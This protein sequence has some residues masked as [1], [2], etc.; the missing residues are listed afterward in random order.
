MLKV[1]NISKSYNGKD[2]LNDINFSLDEG[3]KAGIIGLNGIGKTTLLRIIAGEEK[4]D[5]GKI[6]KDKNSL[7]GY[8][9]QE[10]KISEEDRDIVSFIKNFIGIDVIEK[11]MNEAEK[12]METDESKIQEFC[13]LQEEY[14]RLDGYNIDYKLDQILKKRRYLNFLEDKKKKLCL[15]LFF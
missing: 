8:F 15:L 4:P 6:I 1:E 11:Q 12:A 5:S 7:V 9:K 13:D 2:V 3:E 10:F 14:M